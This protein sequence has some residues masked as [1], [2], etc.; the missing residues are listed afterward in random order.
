MGWRD[1]FDL[2]EGEAGDG[3][4]R[5]TFFLKS[6]IWGTL[7]RVLTRCCWLGSKIGKVLV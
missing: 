1:G 2:F 6:E 7:K 5:E 4:D 3:E